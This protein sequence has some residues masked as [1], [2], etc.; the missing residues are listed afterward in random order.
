M[1]AV[2]RRRARDT[3]AAEIEAGCWW[4]PPGFTVADLDA[5]LAKL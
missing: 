1:V 3:V 5:L 4:L 2:A